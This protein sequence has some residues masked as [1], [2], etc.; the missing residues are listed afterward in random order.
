MTKYFTDE[1]QAQFIHLLTNAE[2]SIPEARLMVQWMKDN[3][4]KT[5]EFDPRPLDTYLDGMT[6]EDKIMGAAQ[7]VIDNFKTTYDKTSL[8][9]DPGG[10][11]KE[12]SGHYVFQSNTPERLPYYIR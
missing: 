1:R 3:V 12:V 11:W 10:Y 5:E 9:F 4:G 8:V 2:I 7:D 6:I